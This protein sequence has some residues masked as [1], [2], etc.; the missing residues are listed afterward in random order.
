MSRQNGIIYSDIAIVSR[1]LRSIGKPASIDRLAKHMGNML[2]V[3]SW[4]L[5]DDIKILLETY[6]PLGFFKKEDGR[7]S[8]P[9]DLLQILNEQEREKQANL[10]VPAATVAP[11]NEPDAVYGYTSEI[12]MSQS[13]RHP[14]LHRFS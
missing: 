10:V 3:P 9:A 4:M 1:G 7:Y 2:G 5:K 11:P 6:E 8:L 12:D 14:Y 13:L